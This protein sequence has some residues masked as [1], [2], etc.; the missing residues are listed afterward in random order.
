MFDDLPPDLERLSTLRVW[1]AMWLARID[2][3]IELLL[4]SQAE[5]DHGRR[6]KPKPPEWIV[7]LGVGRPPV[8]IHRGT[9][10]MPGKRRRPVE[11]DEARRLLADGTSACTHCRPDAHLG[12]IDLDRLTEPHHDA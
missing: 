6:A 3:K 10:Y 12:I 5:Q 8:Q 11:Q 7:E 4:K 2:R 9:C 1:H